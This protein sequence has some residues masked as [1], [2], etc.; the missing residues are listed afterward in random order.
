MNITRA[1]SATQ[2]KGRT[3]EQRQAQTANAR[4]EFKRRA[5]QRA[6]DDPA[7][8]ERAAEV[9]HAAAAQDKLPSTWA[10]RIAATL[11]PF[12]PEEIAEAGR[13]A[14]QIDGRLQA[15]PEQAAS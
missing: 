13:L 9:V 14:A 5:I 15:E 2:K 1:E 7:R 6:V 10:A 4:T 12:T 3:P 8:L 11:P